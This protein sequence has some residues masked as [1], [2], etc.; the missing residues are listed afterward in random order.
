MTGFFV[1][2][3][4]LNGV[5]TSGSML[6]FLTLLLRGFCSVP[7]PDLQPNESFT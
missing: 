1:F 6:R 5:K 7:F 4:T 3:T 2:Q